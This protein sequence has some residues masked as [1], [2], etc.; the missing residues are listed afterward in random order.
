MPR[1]ASPADL[2]SWREDLEKKRAATPT[3]IVVSSGTCGHA[4]GSARVVEAFR[5]E[6]ERRDASGRVALRVTG[7]HGFCQQEP[8]AVVEPGGEFFCR[9]Q[10][11]QVSAIVDAT[12]AGGGHPAIPL[13]C[14]EIRPRRPR[15]RPYCSCAASP[16]SA[17]RMRRACPPT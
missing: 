12:P 6:I 17:G 13:A 14:R 3:V 1:L 10:P 11:E 2:A 8:L 15:T 4:S 5:K 9:I 7:C 16:R